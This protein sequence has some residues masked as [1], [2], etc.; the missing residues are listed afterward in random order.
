MKGEALVRN[1]DPATSHEAAA[2]V[3]RRLSD[4]ESR[5]LLAFGRE[6]GMSARQCERLG[7]FASLSPST[8]RRRITTLHRFGML[9]EHTHEEI[10]RV[11]PR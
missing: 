9:E 7:C 6:G 1:T 5:V 4:L 8:V 10:I 3:G 11:R 2:A